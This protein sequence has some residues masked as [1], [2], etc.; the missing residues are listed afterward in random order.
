MMA[1]DVITV[2]TRCSWCSSGLN[3]SV[4]SA[5]LLALSAF[6]SSLMSCTFRSAA[7]AFNS[8][9]SFNSSS[10][11][12]VPRTTTCHNPFSFNDNSIWRLHAAQLVPLN[13][14]T[15]PL[16]AATRAGASADILG[17][18]LRLITCQK[19]HLSQQGG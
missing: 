16:L 9:C 6:F 2:N 7:S 19:N 3:T 17:S 8:A 4:A 15:I 12:F 10:Y 13:L 1:A 5:L 14:M 18:G 11:A